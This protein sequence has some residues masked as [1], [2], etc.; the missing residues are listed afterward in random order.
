MFKQWLKTHNT[1]DYTYTGRL[2]PDTTD[3]AY[4]DAYTDPRFITEA[5]R[6]LGYNWPIIRATDF[7][8]FKRSGN[9]TIMETPHFA[10]RRALITLAIAEVMENKGRF[11]PEL[12]NGLFLICEES[13]WGLSAHW[14]AE[15][16]NIP[17]PEHPYIDLFAAQTAEELALTYYLLYAPLN[18]CCPEILER[19][20][21]EMNR[22]IFVPYLDHRDYW[23]MGYGLKRTNNWNPWIISNVML[24]FFLVE[25]NP[26]RVETAVYKMLIELQNYYDTMPADGG[27]DEG[28]SYWGVAGLSLFECVYQLK[29]ATD[30][31]IDLLGDEKLRN[32]LAYVEKVYIGNGK[33]INFADGPT[34]GPGRIGEMIY[35]IGRETGQPRLMGLGRALYDPSAD[36]AVNYWEKMRRKLLAIPLR[37]ELETAPAYS[38]ANFA[39]LPDLQVCAL[40]R[41]GWFLGAKG[42]NN[43]EHHN[44][45]DIANFILY[46]NG[47]PVLIDA[48][49]GDYTRQTFSSERYTIWT[50]QSSYHNLPDLGGVAQHNGSKY[51]ADSFTCG[52][53]NVSI[54]FASAYPAEAGVERAERTIELTDAGITVRDSFAFAGET[55]AITEHLMTALEPAIDGSTVTLGGRYVIDCGGGAVSVDK[56]EFAGNAKLQGSWQQTYLWR[57]NVEFAGCTEIKLTVRRI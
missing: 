22:R 9:R 17:T 26:R 18:S 11:L 7:M 3:R 24:A 28:A 5:E 56:V 20:E 41:G 32:I 50:M 8:E 43:A 57:V 13:Y 15:V 27:C 14:Q 54:G 46:D 36:P 25:R 38:P 33:F 1:A 49:V 34:G 35:L 31:A 51:R 4:W 53:D 16:G 21:Y 37:R 44:H 45:N 23:W 47:A 30:G 12:V 40:R 48:G 6:Y 2:F 52:E 55:P 19:I 29:T 42:G 39:C 10:R